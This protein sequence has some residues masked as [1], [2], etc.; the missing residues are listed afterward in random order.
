MIWSVSPGMSLIRLRLLPSIFFL[1][2]PPLVGQGLLIIEALRSH[3]G[4]HTTLGRTPLDEWSARRI[5]LYRKIHNIRK[6]QTCMPP[7]G[8]EPAIPASK[9]PQTHTLDR[10]TT[11][12]GASFNSLSIS[13]FTN[14]PMFQRF[15]FWERTASWE[16]MNKHVKKEMNKK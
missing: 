5:A 7:A 10:A 16:W 6:R 12:I 14:H 1:A 9:R 13:L 11:G 15:I 3:S 2:R 4:R 8:F